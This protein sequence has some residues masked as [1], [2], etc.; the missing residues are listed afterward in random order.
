MLQQFNSSYENLSI[1]DFSYNKINVIGVNIKTNHL[2][3]LVIANNAP[4]TAYKMNQ[5]VS[6]CK[7]HNIPKY[8]VNSISL[9]P[10]MF[11]S[12]NLA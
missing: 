1:N 8:Q 10:N 7:V 6:N 11:E 5:Y 4:K 2:F 12:L 3:L 9:S